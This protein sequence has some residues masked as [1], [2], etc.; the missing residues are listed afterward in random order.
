MRSNA[1]LQPPADTE[2]MNGSTIFTE[3]ALGAMQ[4]AVEQAVEDHHRAGLPV[5]VWQDGRILMLYPDGTTRAVESS[6][7]TEDGE[8]APFSGST[9]PVR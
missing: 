6:V 3:A 7:P 8:A 9:S 4:L 5:A 1:P 2:P